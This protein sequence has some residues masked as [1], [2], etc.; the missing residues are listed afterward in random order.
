MNLWS[1]LVCYLLLSAGI[2]QYN[3]PLK[4]ENCS[5]ELKTYWRNYFDMKGGGRNPLSWNASFS[6][7][8]KRLDKGE[9]ILCRNSLDAWWFYP[10]RQMEW[11]RICYVWHPIDKFTAKVDV[12]DAS[13]MV[14][15][16][17][18][19]H[20]WWISGDHLI[21][22]FQCDVCHFRNVHGRD[23]MS[24][25]MED[26]RLLCAIWWYTLDAFW[27]QRPRTVI[28]DLMTLKRI[29]E[30]G[31]EILG[32]VE[33]LMYMV[34]LPLRDEICMGVAC[35]TLIIYMRKWKYSGQL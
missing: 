33:G 24:Y 28:N 11:C 4:E 25:R 3:G 16:N 5:G 34:P 30:V 17:K 6:K 15:D 13:H 7:C 23:P 14:V 1:L 26:D 18:T 12:E 19:T 2:G 27:S 22:I 35:S 8:Q 10:I 31:D 20:S 32:L 21:K 9:G 29:H